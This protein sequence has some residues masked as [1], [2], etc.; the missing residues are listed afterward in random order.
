[1]VIHDDLDNLRGLASR[2]STHIEDRVVG[3]DIAEDRR[4]HADELLS[5]KQPC[6]L[7]TIYDFV[8][9]LQ[10]LVLLQK[11]LGHEQLVDEVLRVKGLAVDLELIEIDVDISELLSVKV[12]FL[13]HANALV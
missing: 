13:L 4:H 6:I 1:M 3:L 2:R 8:D 9:L 12:I 7:G 10:A 11:L 5:R